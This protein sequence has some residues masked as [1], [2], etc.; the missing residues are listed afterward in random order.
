MTR[1]SFRDPL[2]QTWVGP[3]GVTRASWAKPQELDTTA[4][5][6]LL[7]ELQAEGRWIPAKA[8]AP[9][10]LAALLEP[11]RPLPEKAWEHPRVFF[12]SYAYEWSPAMLQSA[13]WLTLDLN[14]RLLE[15]GWELKDATPTNVLFQG[16]H[17]IFVDHLSPVQRMPGQMGWTA[18]GQFIRTFLIPLCLHRL[19]RL[20]LAWLHQAR[21]DGVSPEDANPQLCLF[22]RFRPSVLGLISLPAFL[23]RRQGTAPLQSLRIWKD[24]DETIG[25]AITLRLLKGLRKRLDRWAPPAAPP[26][27]GQLTTRQVR[28]TPRKG[29]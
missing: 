1:T 4:L 20:P 19:N 9:G 16:P 10:V 2:G 13:A 5:E 7:Q 23:S 26:T 28:A 27:T 8:V 6:F 24:G 15:I 22:D 14:E 18:Y 17:P 11:T 29:C 12:P 25:R 3:D 21:R